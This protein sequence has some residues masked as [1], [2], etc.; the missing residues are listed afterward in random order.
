MSER[1]D[2]ADPAA[3]SQ[4]RSRRRTAASRSRL[5]LWAPEAEP[6]AQS[7]AAVAPTRPKIGL[8]A[9]PEAAASKPGL[10]A[11]SGAPALSVVVPMHN[12]AEV[13]DSFFARLC[14]VL[15]DLVRDLGRS[16]EIVC[17]NDGSSDA[18]F[19]RLMA[20]RTA[21]PAIKIVDLSRNFGKDVAL[22]AGLDHASGAAVIPIDADLQ[23]PPEVI[24]QLF[25]KWLEG[26]DVVYAERRS[27]EGDGAVK[28]MTAGWF[29]RCYNRIAEV[30]IPHDTGDFRL[31]D[32]RVVEAIRRLPER[33]R[34]MKGIFSWVGFKQVGVPYARE[35]RQ[36]GSSKWR[37]WQLWNFALDGITA[38]STLPLRIW[39][40][41]GLA[42]ALFAFLLGGYL[43]LDT[44]I[45]GVE[46]PGYASIMAVVL[47]F[48][49]LNL[50]GL[51]V[52]GEYIGRI[53]AETLGRPLYLVQD[54][55]GF[56][57]RRRSRRKE[58]APSSDRAR[59][60]IQSRNDSRTQNS[61]GEPW[62]ARSTAEWR[63]SKTG[64][65]GS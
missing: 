5:Q 45:T 48:G 64:T 47:F 28:R 62:T 10:P 43:V 60:T 49:A 30:A 12:E 41:L 56:E 26:H 14:P 18:T 9:D 39:T 37:Y 35:P 11:V 23:D 65:G 8:R 16:Y 21:N 50:I 52:L 7:D 20:H 58:D 3:A 53:R 38:S 57:R 1:K 33:N 24:P 42:G 2:P 29:Y 44:L 31:M 59:T 51:G 15:D 13:L 25:A 19:G 55:I 40:Y 22:T 27:R 34:F 46:V 4:A 17:V 32:Y 6:K 54:C 63:Q 61:S 36:A